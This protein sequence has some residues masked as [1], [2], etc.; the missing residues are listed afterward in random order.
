MCLKY[1]VLSGF[2]AVNGHSGL[3]S[4]RVANVPTVVNAVKGH[5]I[6]TYPEVVN[7]PIRPLC[8]I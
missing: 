8:R 3:R 4:P 7:R 5:T 6:E 1:G 2:P